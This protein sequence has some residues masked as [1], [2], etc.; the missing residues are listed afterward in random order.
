ML[1]SYLIFLNFLSV[2]LTDSRKYILKSALP[3]IRAGSNV[4]L[5]ALAIT[6][7]LISWIAAII[8][9]PLNTLAR[10]MESASGRQEC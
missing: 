10:S 2:H 5:T 4:K 1:D 9:S 7:I 8:T 3:A 6:V